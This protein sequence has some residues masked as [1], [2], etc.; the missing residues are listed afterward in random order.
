MAE[1]KKDPFDKKEDLFT[2]TGEL[3][4][5]YDMG[6]ARAYALEHAKKT[7]GE[8]VGKGRGRRLLVW[9]IDSSRFDEDAECWEV[10]LSC[11]PEEAQVERPGRWVY[12]VRPQGGLLPGTPMQQQSLVY[13][14]PEAP[15]RGINWPAVTAIATV[16]LAVIGLGAWLYSPRDGPSVTP[17]PVVLLATAT[18]TAQPSATSA[19][20]QTPTLTPQPTTKP[21]PTPTP[22]PM[23]RPPCAF[24]DDFGGPLLWKEE[25]RQPSPD[26]GAGAPPQVTGKVAQEDGELHVSADYWWYDV[27]AVRDVAGCYGDFE[28]SVRF[29][30]MPDDNGD[31]TKAAL[32][33]GGVA[34][35]INL[36]WV[37][38]IRQW[39]AEV[40]G[41]QAKVA[42]P[43]VTKDSWVRV[44]VRRVGPAYQFLVNDLV[45]YQESRPDPFTVSYVA[46]GTSVG[47]HTEGGT[48]VHFDDFALTMP[49]SR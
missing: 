22:T 31:S 4:G 23:P 7:Q 18:S 13:T 33:L 6:M 46:L 43:T 36:V 3:K 19:G 27:W 1:Q 40:L 48:H 35:T 11:Q 47:V 42:D 41:T 34:Q 24:Q 20:A 37:G 45:I 29:K 16:A 17:T 9:Q 14:L 21:M 25:P 15:R 8:Y 38:D 30:V 44:G 5:G 12:H 2:P 26:W 49:A 39:I 10:V 32:R 28:A